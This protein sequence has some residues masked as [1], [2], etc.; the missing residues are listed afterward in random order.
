MRKQ[1]GA[2]KYLIVS[3]HDFHPGSREAIEEQTIFLN[4]LG[5]G[6]TALLVVPDFHARGSVFEDE[7]SMAFLRQR[8]AAG[9]DLVLHGFY[10]RGGENASGRRVFWNRFYTANEAEFL[11]LDDDE[12]RARV[13]KGM[14]PWEREKW[15]LSGF[16]APA[17][18]MPRRQDALLKELGFLYTVRLR[19]I[20]LIGR[21]RIEHTQ[22]LCYSTRSRWRRDVSLIWNRFLLGRLRGK[23][24]IRLSLHPD[25][26]KWPALRKQIG[27]FVEMILA[28]GYEP[29]TYGKYAEM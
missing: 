4:G 27:R 3:L 14:E 23:T 29:V 24:V 16:I 21:D 22:S 28:D 12:F 19:E 11:E 1:T 15:K 25:D 18:L 20:H 8:H 17:W 5:V 10:H 9:D 6:N 7:A 13:S 26:L 2:M